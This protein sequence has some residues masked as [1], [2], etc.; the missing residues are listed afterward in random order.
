MSALTS[1]SRTAGG[2]G[3]SLPPGSGAQ[4]DPLLHLGNLALLRRWRQVA[5]VAVGQGVGDFPAT[6]APLL[7]AVFGR[8]LRAIRMSRHGL[9]LPALGFGLAE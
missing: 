1:R 8:P 2:R 7:R 4:V 5:A 9:Y 3:F 6:G